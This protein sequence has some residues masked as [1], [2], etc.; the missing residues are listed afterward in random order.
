MKIYH[1]LLNHILTD[2]NIRTDRT[3]T[4]TQSVFG[5]QFRHNLSDGFPLLTTKYIYF[6]AVVYELL[7]YLRGDTNIAYLNNH[8]VYIWDAWATKTPHIKVYGSRYFEDLVNE[9]S[10]ITKMSYND[11][12]W[13]LNKIKCQEGCG[14]LAAHLGKHRVIIKERHKHS[15]EGDLGPIY[16]KQWRE[17]RRTNNTDVD[18]VRDLVEGLK[19]NPYSRRHI[20]SAWNVGELDEMHLPPCVCFVQFYVEPSTEYDRKSFQDVNEISR[21]LLEKTEKLS[22]HIYQRSADA[23]IGVPFNI[24]TYSLL[25]HMLAHVC[26]YI[27]GDFIHSFGDLHL[28]TTHIEKAQDQLKRDIQKLPSL[29]LD[30][31]VTSIDDFDFPEITLSGYNPHS[32]I[33]ADVSV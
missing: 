9:Y 18:Q 33:K 31:K 26:G 11:A 10:N 17:W 2:G 1:D 30:P 3:G 22:C 24:A 12:Y 19:N 32:A 25:T 13:E 7:W 21:P 4:G 6:K 28:Y 20:L 5:Y 15:P 27:P 23:F 14:A 8:N 16:G 29:T